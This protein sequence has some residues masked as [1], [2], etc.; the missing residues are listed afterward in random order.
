MNAPG[1][2]LI[3]WLSAIS[4][5]SVAVC[6]FD[7]RRSKRSGARRVPESALLWLS[8]L[9]GASAMLITMLLIRHK[10]RK[11]KFMIGIP[12]IIAIHLCL[13]WAAYRLIPPGAL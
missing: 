9:G 6:V 10:T 12:V 4:V 13:L 7:K 3:I 11:A 8:A 1:Y 5:I 2:A